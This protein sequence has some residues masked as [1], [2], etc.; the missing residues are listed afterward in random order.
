MKAII[1]TLIMLCMSA[2]GQKVDWTGVW[3]ENYVSQQKCCN[4]LSP[5]AIIQTDLGLHIIG[6]L[7]S[8]CDSDS[9]SEQKD[10]LPEP[11]ENSFTYTYRSNR[12]ATS[13]TFKKVDDTLTLQT[14]KSDWDPKC[15]TTYVRKE[16]A[17]AVDWSGFWKV[18]KG[19]YPSSCCYPSPV[20]NIT[21]NNNKVHIQGTWD[22]S[23]AC[24]KLGRDGDNFTQ[25]SYVDDSKTLELF[26]MGFQDFIVDIK[27]KDDSIELGYYKDQRQCSIT[28]TK[29]DET[30]AKALEVKKAELT[31]AQES[32]SKK[33]ESGSNWSLIGLIIA[34]IV[35][36][37]LVAL[38][39][40]NR[41]NA[42]KARLQ[43]SHH[44]NLL[45]QQL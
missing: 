32:G 28:L 3:T 34:V 30:T 18:A 15:D 43:E 24:V 39:V 44:E 21:Q 37:V 12:Y 4:M 2:H 29:T 20:V 42:A 8:T 9:G 35:I 31:E 25:A 16:L 6:S 17:K 38:L 10:Y 23:K 26:N 27:R 11:T 45:R 22:T 41:Q 14:A 1:L 36:L 13:Q 40:Y 7:N 33:S 5:F 19:S